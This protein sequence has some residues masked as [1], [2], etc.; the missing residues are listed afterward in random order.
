M[1]IGCEN[2]LSWVQGRPEGSSWSND[3]WSVV[4]PHDVAFVEPRWGAYF[5][6]ESEP[7]QFDPNTLQGGTKGEEDLILFLVWQLNMLEVWLLDL[8]L[9]SQ[10][11]IFNNIV[12]TD[13]RVFRT[14]FWCWTSNK[15]C[16][17]DMFSRIW[18]NVLTVIILGLVC[19]NCK[20]NRFCD[21]VSF[22]NVE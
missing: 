3:F 11:L 22:Q 17:E 12:T 19:F 10:F 8:I 18:R 16:K 20:P 14:L 13:C 15:L 6:W 21:K 1:W 4:S 5:C 7:T 9:H 2:W